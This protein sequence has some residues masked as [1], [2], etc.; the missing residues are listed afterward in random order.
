MVCWGFFF[1]K[2]APN[3]IDVINYKPQTI[4]RCWCLR[5]KKNTMALKRKLELL[6]KKMLFSS[7]RLKFERH[8]CVHHR[9]ARDKFSLGFH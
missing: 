1:L 5:V 7:D 9:L 2:F 3:S 6:M 4:H 8:S